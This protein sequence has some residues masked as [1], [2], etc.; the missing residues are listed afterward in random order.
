[1]A[2]APVSQDRSFEDSVDAVIGANGVT[3]TYGEGEA[4]VHA[5]RDTT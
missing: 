4:A 2:I 5:L 1:M 3:R